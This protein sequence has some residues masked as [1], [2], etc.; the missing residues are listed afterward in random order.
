MLITSEHGQV[1]DGCIVTSVLERF[2]YLDT[3]ALDG[4]LSAV[5]DGLRTAAEVEEQAERDVKGDVD[6]KL[7]RGG[8]ARKTSTAGRIERADTSH[9][10][11]RR[12]IDAVE[13]DP[14][15]F[16][17]HEIFDPD[18]QFNSTGI[19]AL[20]SVECELYIPD[21]IRTMASGEFTQA[22]ELMQNLRP[23]AGTFGLDM[24]GM[25][26]DDEL[27]SMSGIIGGISADQV[28]VGEIDGSDWRIAGRL[29]KDF[30]QDSD[31]DCIA[32]V[33][34]KVAKKWNE[35]EWKHLL[36][37]PG[38]NLLPRSE[39]RRL[40]KQQPENPDDDSYLQGPAVMLDILAVYR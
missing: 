16:G 34:G 14:D 24:E 11:F 1:G 7:V 4:Y 5:E 20:V 38:A 35:G 2:L 17:W 27:R 31:F 36:A 19:G 28:L 15:K 30:L 8:A 12:L 3:N 9:A 37:L 40:E 29:R 10:R 33:V 25:P 13:S 21:A 18:N 32:R 6:A 26:D 39:R 22:I 23:M